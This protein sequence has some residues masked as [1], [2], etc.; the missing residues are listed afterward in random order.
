MSEIP[1]PYVQE[2]M[3]QFEEL[4]ASEKEKVMFI[5]FNH[6]N[7][8]ILNS[9]ER[10]QVEGLGYRVAKEGDIIPMN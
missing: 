1:H 10:E 5:H 8:L 9:S 7:P 3:Q 6:T 4:P 2:S